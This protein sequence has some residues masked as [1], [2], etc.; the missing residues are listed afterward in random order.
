MILWRRVLAERR[1][2]VVPLLAAVA[3]NV[4]VLVLVVFPLQASVGGDESRANEAKVE[5]A[6]ARRAEA[7]ATET[8]ASKLRAD[9]ELKKFYSEVLPANHAAARNLLFVQVQHFSQQ[10]GL[11]LASS[12]FE[13]EQVD[14]SSLMRFYVDVT[15]TGEYANIRKFV[16]LL[17]TAP[18]F[19]VIE[20][21]KLAQSNLQGG[22]GSVEVV[23]RVA[24]YYTG[25]RQ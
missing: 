3:V 17:E 9:V 6:N 12:A 24:T 23:L 10:T 8:R 25:G 5:L 22:G 2:L 21:I 19:F 7:L 11:A 16:Y 4:A 1:G 15:L 14:D 18:E 13:P 20:S